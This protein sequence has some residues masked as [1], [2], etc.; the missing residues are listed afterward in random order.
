MCY[1]GK[2]GHQQKQH[3]RSVFWVPVQLSGDSHQSQETG[4]LE[5]PDQCGGLKQEENYVTVSD[6]WDADQM[7]NMNKFVV[8]WNTV[9]ILFNFDWMEQEH[10]GQIMKRKEAKRLVLTPPRWSSIL[11]TRGGGTKPHCFK[12][13]Q[14]FLEMHLIEERLLFSN[15][16]CVKFVPRQQNP[17]FSPFWLSNS[18]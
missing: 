6:S 5:Q 17:R 12:M 14:V 4:C 1:Q 11:D 3:G 15:D 10:K 7:V 18:L 2:G 13:S 9:H 8:L 16:V